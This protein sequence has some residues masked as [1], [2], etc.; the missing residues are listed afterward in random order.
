MTPT[1]AAFD[2]AVRAYT[3]YVEACAQTDK[4]SKDFYGATPNGRTFEDFLDTAFKFVE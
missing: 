1:E 2:A 4:D 3:A